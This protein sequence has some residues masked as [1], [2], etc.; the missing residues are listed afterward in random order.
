MSDHDRRPPFHEVLERFLYND[1]R[2]TIETRCRF[3]EHEDIG[4]PEKRP[5]NGNTLA[6]TT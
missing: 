2:L 1:L 4:V 3:I 6:L 5:R